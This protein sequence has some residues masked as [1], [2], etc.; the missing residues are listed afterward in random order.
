MNEKKTN[1]YIILQNNDPD[2]SYQFQYE[3][4]NGI[5]GKE[6]GVG[7][8]KAEGERQWVADDGNTYKFTYVADENGFQPSGDHLPQQPP[9][10]A[11]LIEWLEAHPSD[12]DGS[13]KPQ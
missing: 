12:D 7:G 3:T 2:G 4:S 13:Y 1:N 8:V 11:R 9:Y 6:E 5:L 10:V